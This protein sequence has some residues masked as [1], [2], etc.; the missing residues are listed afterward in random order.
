MDS[1]TPTKLLY[2]HTPIK[3]LCLP[4]GRLRE[5]PVMTLGSGFFNATEIGIQAPQ[6]AD[7]EYRWV[8]RC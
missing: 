5:A 7:L 4:L 3:R 1:S 8:Y 6:G 2:L